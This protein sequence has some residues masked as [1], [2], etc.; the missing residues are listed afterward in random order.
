MNSGW[1]LS[2]AGAIRRGEDVARVAGIELSDRRRPIPF[3]EL[4]AVCKCLNRSLHT[5]AAVASAQLDEVIRRSHGD[6]K[7]LPADAT[8]LVRV[9][10][11]GDL[12][13]PYLWRRW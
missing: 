1:P 8:E 3:H 11:A 4:E 12:R 9:H 7:E 2:A 13:S 5:V 10:A 6:E